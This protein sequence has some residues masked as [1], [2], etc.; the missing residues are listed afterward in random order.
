MTRPFAF[1][2][3]ALAAFTS[4][5]AAAQTFVPLK[6]QPP[7][8]AGVGL[9]L[10]DGTVLFQGNQYS[11]WYRLTPDI[12]GS[13]QNG[14]WT[15]AASLAADYTPLYF[16]SA[17]LPD[18]R[19]IIAGGEY[20]N[21]QFA[22]TNQ[23]AIFD[24]IANRWTN[25]PA[26]TGWDFIGDAAS[27]V[28]ANGQFMIGSKFDKRLAV[29]N[30]ATLTWTAA[31]STGKKDIN[32]EEGW[33]LLPNGTLLTW[34]VSKAPLSEI[35]DPAAAKWQPAGNT[36]VLL[37][38]PP[39]V[40]IVHYGNGL[41]YRPPGEVGPGILRPD[42]TVFAAGDIPKNANA[43]N[44][45]I[46]TPAK[47]G[48]GTWKAGPVFP[49]GVSAGDTAAALLPSGNVLI[50][51]SDNILYE[52]DGAKLIP[53]KFTGS[54]YGSLLILPTGEAIVSGAA[55]YRATGA[56]SPAWAPAFTTAPSTVTRG[57]TYAISGTQFNGLSQ[58]ASFGDEVET[59][60]NY[61]LVRIV[62]NATGHVFYARTHGHSTMA[63]AT[64][65]AIVSTNFDVPAAAE[66]GASSLVVVA[67]GIASAG[68]GVT[69]Q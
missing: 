37:K 68:V 2:L 51:G 48:V 3:A 35:Y 19:A 9:L 36:P 38:G 44:T 6:H 22:F 54:T 13:Y 45:A 59:A 16:A 66:A 60:T 39:Y 34:D 15:K 8:G 12:N 17:V 53:S 21:G 25:V 26:P 24:P 63:V 32:A 18:G 56:P 7:D 40:K 1:L 61:P 23:C 57:S 30:A 47:H 42:G 50:E 69:V 58:A 27:A 67:N 55:L 28:L 10:T 62:N 29:L 64:G 11:D 46:Y 20:N 43:A 33:T 4:L 5:T 49:T 41:I 14:T 65:A 31:A 52:F